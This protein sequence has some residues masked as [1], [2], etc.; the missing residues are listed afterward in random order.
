LKALIS[1]GIEVIDIPMSRGINP[2]KD[3]LALWRLCR[4][5]KLRKY[6]IIHGHSS[7]AG[8]LGRLAARLAN[9]N[10]VTVYSPHAIAIRHN[11]IYYYL[12]RM[13]ASWTDCMIAVSPSE[14]IELCGYNIVPPHKIHTI[15]AGIDIDRIPLGHGSDR[16]RSSL[17]LETGSPLVGSVGRLVEQKDP[18]TYL[19]MA[20][21]VLKEIPS[22]H[23]VWIGDGDLKAKVLR[24]IERRSLSKQVSVLPFCKDV[25][26]MISEFDLFAL[27]SRYESFGYVTCEAMAVGVP[28][29]ATA[30]P[31]TVDLVDE[32]S[33]R[34]CAPG[35]I[36]GLAKAVIQLL[37]DPS[38]RFRLG[39]CA[40]ERIRNKFSATRMAEETGKLYLYLLSEGPLR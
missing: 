29:V 5:I 23:F 20:V 3:A 31:G 35:D 25:W 7:K 27:T 26:Q 17:N 10:A 9:R 18:E 8:F 15:S 38:T 1:H 12:E 24:E 40:A 37:S 13:A 11:R 28:V 36:D 39:K 22:C 19:A 16:V 33:G 34:L 14:R 2:L 32:E 30:V 4:I 6:E 21:K